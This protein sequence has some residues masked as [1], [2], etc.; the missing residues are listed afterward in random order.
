MIRRYA[1]AGVHLA[2]CNSYSKNFGLYGERIGSL[3]IVTESS[4]ERERLLS[5]LKN[6]ARYTS[7][8]LS[9]I[10]VFLEQVTQILPF[11]E[12]DLLLKF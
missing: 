3:S 1:E 2:V 11:M 6:T 7:S 8:K 9:H 4:D 5:L 12:Q 10:T